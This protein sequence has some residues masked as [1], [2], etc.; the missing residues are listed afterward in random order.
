MCRLTFIA[1]VENIFMVASCILLR[2]EAWSHN[3]SLTPT[4]FYWSACIQP[5][6]WAVLYY[7]CVSGID[8]V[9]VSSTFILY[10]GGAPS[11]VVSFSFIFHLITI[12]PVLRG[13]LWDKVKVVLLDRWPLKK[14]S[15][16]MKFSKTGL[17]K[18]DCLIEVTAWE[19]LTNLLIWI[20]STIK[21]H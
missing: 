4:I 6:K 19:G 10:F 8:F 5:E 16:H 14:G 1:C 13:H 18:G 7:M 3:T 17:E 2:G 15:I 12:T 21:R 20:I 9:S 11:G